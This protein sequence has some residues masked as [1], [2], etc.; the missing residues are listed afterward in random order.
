MSESTYQINISRDDFSKLLNL[1][2]IFENSCTD[3]D[4]QSGKFRCRTN[5]RQAI[6]DM[7]LTSILQ[8]NN[9]SF[10]LIK[11]K[12]ALLKTFELDDNVQVEDKTVKIE[13]NESNYEI[14]DPFSRMIFRKPIQRYIDNQYIPEEDFNQMVRLSEDNLLFSYTINNYMKKRIANV[15]LGFQTDVVLCK[16]TNVDDHPAAELS[17]STTNHEDNSVVAKDI[18]MNRGVENKQ[19]KML[20]L[21]FM[22]DMASDLKLNCYHVSDGVALVKFDQSFYGVSISILT[23]VK[24]TNI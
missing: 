7:D 8:T 4:I 1:L 12:I 11:N 20:A 6:I 2:K 23:Q 15:A 9:L 13:S 14:F 10:S 16:M 18:T 5:D 3:C 19:F 22:L 17:V 21:P 24:V